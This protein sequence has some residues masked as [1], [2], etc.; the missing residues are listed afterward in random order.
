[1]THLEDEEMRHVFGLPE[2]AMA[3]TEGFEIL[4]DS[5]YSENFAYSSAGTR[6]E[7]SEE[8]AT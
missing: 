3:V 6:I 4:S 5:W 1:M 2:S 7:L 8:D